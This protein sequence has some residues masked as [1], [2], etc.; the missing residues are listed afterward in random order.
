LWLSQFLIRK[1]KPRPRAQR[2]RPRVDHTATRL[3]DGRIS[4]GG[5]GATGPLSSAEMFDPANPGAGFQVLTSV[6][7]SRVRIIPLRS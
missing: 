5:T 3:A 2:S 6:M 4:A 7:T 1:A